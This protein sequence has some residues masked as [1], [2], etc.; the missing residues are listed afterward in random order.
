M[1]K[2]LNKEAT[3]NIAKFKRY[4]KKAKLLT[5]DELNKL[6]VKADY[7]I[8]G[9]GFVYTGSA[10]SKKFEKICAKT[11]KHHFHTHYQDGDGYEYF[12]DGA[13][14]VN[15]EGYGLAHGKNMNPKLEG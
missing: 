13:G 9:F 7:D 12:A 3:M 11:K 2:Y 1:I 6:G 14:Y 15:R 8:E 4:A 10:K 5:V